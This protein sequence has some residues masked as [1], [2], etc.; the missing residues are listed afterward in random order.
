V[1]PGFRL[2]ATPEGRLLFAVICAV[3]RSS[4]LQLHRRDRQDSTVPLR[5]A[6]QEAPRRTRRRYLVGIV[7]R[8]QEA[9]PEESHDPNFSTGHDATCSNPNA[10]RSGAETVD[11]EVGRSETVRP[12]KCFTGILRKAAESD[13]ML[14]R[15]KRCEAGR[16]LELPR[17][18]NESLDRMIMR[19]IG[20]T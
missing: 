3:L 8:F 17:L 2:S 18:M 13:G 19:F 12:R 1:V 4:L 11:R 20:F 16:L 10:L 9:R 6:G 5:Q 7:S 14:R 15:Q